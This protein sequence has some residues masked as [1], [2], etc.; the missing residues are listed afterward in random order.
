VPFIR[1]PAF[2]GAVEST[3]ANTI[4]VTGAAWAPNQ[5]VYAVGTQPNRY[6]AL[7]G[8]GGSANAKEGHTYPIVENTANSLTLDPGQ[9]DLAGIPANAKILIIPNWTLKSVFPVSDQN[10]SFTPTTSTAAYKTQVR[11]PD[12]SAPGINVP[13]A[14]YY[15][16]DNAWRLVGDEAT[17]RGD[18][19]LLPDSYFI[20]RNLNGA[21]TLPLVTKG[22]V[23]LDKISVPLMTS[24]GSQID[25]PVGLLRPIDV[26]LNATGLNRTDGSFGANDQLL[27]FNNTQTGYDKTPTVYYVAGSVP[28]G[29]WRRLNDATMSDRGGDIIPA[30]AGFIV[31]KAQTEGGQTAF[32]TNSMPVRAAAA[33]SRKTHG[34]AG[35]FDIDLPLAGTPG[36][37]CR[38]SGGNHTIVFTFPAPVTVS[39]AAVTSGTAAVGA[40]V[41]S[42]AGSKVTVHL[43]GVATIQR[44]TVTL[45]GVSDGLNLNDVAV[46]MGVL[47]GDTN[48]NG[49]VNASDIGQTKSQSGQAIT[50][51]NFRQDVNAN[52]TMSSSDVGLIKANSGA[53]LPAP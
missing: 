40:P 9:D 39:G 18:D 11:V 15:F 8:S 52:G 50:A 43:T 24:T 17:D 37:E 47:P 20:V 12:V 7:I 4:T 51:A 42:E 25:N 21:P 5:F 1:Q 46:R 32:W 31:R 34:S 13:Y 22:S 14:T 49:E 33:V 2:V 10:I 35:A 36:V 3:S 23:L 28:F 16:S 19:P 26:P 30:G 45:L 53:V 6:Y 44:I 29:P 48:G 38:D 27:L 41:L